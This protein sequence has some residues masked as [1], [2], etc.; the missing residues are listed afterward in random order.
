MA[1]PGVS[2][3]GGFSY[4]Q[5]AKG[6]ASTAA[7][8]TSSSKVT[9]GAATPATGLL[10]DFETASPSNW[11]DDEDLA[12][13]D[14][15]P[16]SNEDS[17]ETSKPAELKSVVERAK[18]EEKAQTSSGVSS[19]DIAA[20]ATSNDDASSANN[21]SSHTS[22]DAKS[23]TSE[24]QQTPEAA[25]SK[26]W[27]TDRAERAER[28]ERQSG[29]HKNESSGK[30]RK[31]KQ[32]KSEE[33]PAPPPKPV[34][35][36]EAP[37]PTV[38]P[39]MKRAEENKAKQAAVPAPAPKAP[40]AQGAAA[41]LKENQRPR[42]DSKKKNNQAASSAETN[43]SSD[44]KKPNG[45]QGKRTDEQ[46]PATR[47]GAKPATAQR[48]D[49]NVPGFSRPAARDERPNAAAPPPVKDEVSW[50]TPDTAPAPEPKERKP[51][52]E[53]D[54]EDKTE[55]NASAGKGRKKQEWKPVPVVPNI[56]W[57]TPS[58]RDRS[59]RG[60]PSSSEGRSR[61]GA[62]VRGRGNFRGS[63][64]GVASRGAAQA[65]EAR[66]EASDDSTAKT[67]R[68]ASASSQSRNGV[69]PAAQ[70][71]KESTAGEAKSVQQRSTKAKAETTNTAGQE[72]ETVPEAIPRGPKADEADGATQNRDSQAARPAPM[73][74]PSARDGNW[75]TPGR[76]AKRGG[77]GR[78]GSREFVNGHHNA[79]PFVNGNAG[80]DFTGVSP[81]GA[82][83]SPS[84]QA[85]RGNH[86]GAFSGP[87]R[88]GWRG[89][90]RAQSFPVENNN[91]RFPGFQ[92]PMQP[93]QGL[94]AYGGY[95]VAA[96]PYDPLMDPSY[97]FGVVGLQVEYY[98][99]M[100]NLL[101]DMFLRKNMDSQGFVYLEVIASFNRVKTLTQD[102]ELLRQVCLQSEAVEI[103]VGED[104]K[105]RVRKNRD[106]QQFI[107]P[108]DERFPAARYEGPKQLDIP[109][110][111]MPA[112]YGQMN[113]NP[114]LAHA[115][116]MPR[117]GDRRDNAFA[118]MNG[119]ARGAYFSQPQ[120][121]SYGEEMR[122]RAQ[123]SPA[124]DSNA[125]NAFVSNGTANAEPDVFPDY[126]LEQLT[127][128]VRLSSRRVPYH[129]SAA[130][131]F[132]NGSIDQKSIPGEI[133][134]QS[135]Q[136]QP[137]TNGE[138]VANGVA[139][140]VP[141]RPTSPSTTG[142]PER[143]A[144][145]AVFW[146]K[147]TE[148]PV[149]TLPSDLTPEPYVQLRL[150]AFEQ[151]NHAATGTCPYDLK[152]LYQFWSHFLIRNFN[153]RMYSE[154]KYYA[155]ADAKDR[156]SFEGHKNLIKYYGEAV[157]SANPI[158]ARVIK[159]YVELVKAEGL[160]SDSTAFKSLQA[161]W[162]NNALNLRNRKLLDESIDDALKAKLE[163]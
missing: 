35:L 9:S 118:M 110:Q 99:S 154:F 106:Y 29:S 59:T 31:N 57:E 80:P 137:K 54:S 30:G 96:V 151:R 142:S 157:G 56:L 125:H 15:Q 140:P 28:T 161:A 38:N 138:A 73:E 12:A 66:T 87:G 60:S 61:G 72:S 97:L 128:C 39:W 21:A 67:Q 23:Q 5:A 139:S 88:A 124:F 8:A 102:W 49:V 160:K 50:P 135:T 44:A 114:A 131:T 4:A 78:G 159:D 86:Q 71:T 46:R 122:G 82:P 132:S 120:D 10:S 17:H 52:P 109:E 22:W 95:P 155:D 104:G 152:V 6:R 37:A 123:K 92:G 1:G 158:P 11:A 153:N 84:F 45:S 32:E 34:V 18:A 146:I 48:A 58:M 93:Y 94:F 148:H 117:P 100:D 119:A 53:K 70:Q 105:E 16:Q 63:A 145:V 47:Q 2:S 33:P 68:S 62:A 79:H 91:Y 90:S 69:K 85:S 134:K 40:Q 42:A 156:V 112:V 41:N 129:N 20:S 13:V 133:S 43:T 76:G 162:R 107:L 19:P 149:G 14:K 108:M 144:G 64:N 98:F 113:L 7:S 65:G 111:R 3:P 36:T 83:Q 115:M 163:A 74:K 89:N 24:T 147:D 103:R 130:R 26:S 101:K 116:T 126:K 51:S 127:V 141:S 77:R 81:F 75:N 25:S 27:I 136:T 143:P 150:K 55:E 121:G